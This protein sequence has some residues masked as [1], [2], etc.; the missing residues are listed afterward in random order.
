MKLTL[1]TLYDQPFA[2]VG[3]LCAESLRRWAPQ[4]G[5]SFVV[6]DNLLSANLA[7]SWNKV[8]AVQAEVWVGESDWV[9]WVDADCIFV[10][11]F[12]LDGALSKQPETVDVVPSRD[13]NGI[14]FGF[15][16]A[17]R[18][19]WTLRFLNALLLCGDV[20]DDDRWGKGFGCKWEQNA[21]KLLQAEFP[22]V[23]AHIGKFEYEFVTDNPSAD[24]GWAY[25][26]HHYGARSNEDRIRGMS[27]ELEM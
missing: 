25:P 26:V 24:T 20:A 18:S 6:R 27:K 7:P 5:Y 14:C 17:R 8:L 1:V 9:V 11:P 19:A 12:D 16:A 10:K 3:E 15:F 13:W 2:A 22:A 21:A 4:M 23:A